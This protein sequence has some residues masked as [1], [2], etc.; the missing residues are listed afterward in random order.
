MP[1]S[2]PARRR[3]G[4]G[5]E[6]SSEDGKD[7]MQA[8]A[9]AHTTAFVSR[10][11]CLHR[12]D[13]LAAVSK[14]C[15]SMLAARPIAFRAAPGAKWRD[16]KGGAGDLCVVARETELGT[17]EDL[18]WGKSGELRSADGRRCSL[19][20]RLRVRPWRDVPA[21]R[22]KRIPDHCPPPSLR[23]EP[24]RRRQRTLGC[25]RIM[26][27]MCSESLKNGRTVAGCDRNNTDAPLWGS[28]VAQ[29]VFRKH[30]APPPYPERG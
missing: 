28:A 11:D 1:A 2:G 5:F 8:W 14:G 30:G 3:R 4:I 23:I 25:D 18:S 13:V 29:R 27:R 9:R 21:A 10:F 22:A 20:R 24:G 6:G 15:A 26:L 19:A 12:S 7:S 16:A 17:S